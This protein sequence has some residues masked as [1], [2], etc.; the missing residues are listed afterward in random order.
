MAAW[1]WVLVKPLVENPLAISG[2]Q[3]WLWPLLALTV[4]VAI[5]GLALLVVGQRPW[6]WGMVAL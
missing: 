2:Y 6:R 5:E 3:I 4:L 1:F